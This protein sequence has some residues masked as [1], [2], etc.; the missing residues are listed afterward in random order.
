MKNLYIT[1]FQMKHNPRTY[2]RFDSLLTFL[3]SHNII[4]FRLLLY[5]PVI[6]YIPYVYVCFTGH[7]L[8][9]INAPIQPLYSYNIFL[10]IR[11]T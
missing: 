3:I 5:R 2:S 6:H 10:Q 7:Q 8:H 9:I 11:A 4:I 1:I